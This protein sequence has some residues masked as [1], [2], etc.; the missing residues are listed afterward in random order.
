MMKHRPNEPQPDP[1][2]HL[3]LA[4]LEQK[5]VLSRYYSGEL[6]KIIHRKEDGSR[7]R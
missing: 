4:E 5:I 7:R 6:K 2:Y 1:A 3:S